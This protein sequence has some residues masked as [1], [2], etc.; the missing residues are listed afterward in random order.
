MASIGWRRAIG[1]CQFSLAPAC[2]T[3]VNGVAYTG[4]KHHRK[5]QYTTEFQFGHN[6]HIR[7]LVENGLPVSRS[8]NDERP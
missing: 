3:I 4:V 6:V 1:W 2:F 7:Q 5:A 8:G